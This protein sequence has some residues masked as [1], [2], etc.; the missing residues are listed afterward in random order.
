MRNA[1]SSLRKRL[2]PDYWKKRF[3]K[4]FY[5]RKARRLWTKDSRA[6]RRLDEVLR[7]SK[8]TG[9]GVSDYWQIYEMVRH[10]K[11]RHILECGCGVSTVV[12][13]Q[14]ILANAQ[15]GHV[16]KFVSMEENEYYRSQI[17]SLLDSEE[18]PLVEI[19]RSDVVRRDYLGWTGISYASRP[20]FAYDLVFIDGPV[21]DASERV[22]N[23][24]LL[25]IAS[26]SNVRFTAM[27][28]GRKKTAERL[29]YLLP[30]STGWDLRYPLP[31]IQTCAQDLHPGLAS[32]A[33]QP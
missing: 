30:G 5:I 24:D 26:R 20:N 22:F 13:C 32:C 19:I 4:R 6:Q 1:W 25:E 11:P 33:T 18:L 23:A 16:A 9:C 31:I 27:I 17:L 7:H 21:L 28:D 3:Y 2:Q 8:S 12:F 10:L 15:E 14:A 29:A